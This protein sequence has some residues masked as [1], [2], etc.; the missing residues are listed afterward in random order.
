MYYKVLRV[1]I[2]R[3][4]VT[5]KNLYYEGSVTLPSSLIRDL[6]IIPGEAVLCVNLNN[7]AR[8]ESYIIEGEKDGEVILNGGAARLG[9]IGDELLLLFFSYL[10]EE[11]IK[12]HKPKIVR[13][14]DRNRPCGR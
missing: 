1:K 2:N 13:L 8:F 5:G 3:A 14:D 10:R 7:G 12:D 4:K 9:E 6:G 11:E